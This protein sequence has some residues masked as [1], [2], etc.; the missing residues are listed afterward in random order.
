[1]PSKCPLG[2]CSSNGAKVFEIMRAMEGTFGSPSLSVL[3]NGSA[4]CCIAPYNGCLNRRRARSKT[5]YQRNLRRVMLKFFA[6]QLFSWLRS[7]T[8]WSSVCVGG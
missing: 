3:F 1:M 5:D 7:M 2:I 8:R 4:N 6:R